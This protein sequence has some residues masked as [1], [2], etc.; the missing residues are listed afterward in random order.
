MP[1]D[2]RQFYVNAVGA[3]TQQSLDP[4]MAW[5]NVGNYHN[6][7]NVAFW[8]CAANSTWGEEWN[9]ASPLIGE[10]A[11]GFRPSPTIKWGSAWDAD[12][13]DYY[14]DAGFFWDPSP[15][16]KFKVRRQYNRGGPVHRRNMG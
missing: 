8:S 1:A 7:V 15:R 4:N 2:I 10:N 6:A 16:L 12:E 5:F 11:F 9:P 14:M 13:I 3:Y